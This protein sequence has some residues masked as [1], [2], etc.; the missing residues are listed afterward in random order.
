MV[1]SG[2]VYGGFYVCLGYSKTL[3]K[4]PREGQKEIFYLYDSANDIILGL[5]K[6]Y[7][8]RQRLFYVT[9]KV[10]IVLLNGKRKCWTI[11]KRNGSA[12]GVSGNITIWRLTRTRSQV[13]QLWCFIIQEILGMRIYKNAY[14]QQDFYEI[15]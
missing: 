15:Q 4:I 14:C 2:L 1:Y 9:F 12:I 8:L 6:G 5:A 11:E 3:S 13:A 10:S 7:F